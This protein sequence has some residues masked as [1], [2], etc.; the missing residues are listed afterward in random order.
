MGNKDIRREKKKPKQVK[1]KSKPA[2][3]AKPFSPRPQK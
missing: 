3:A 1:D 2:T